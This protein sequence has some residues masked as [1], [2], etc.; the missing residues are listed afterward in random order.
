MATGMLPQG[1]SEAS[2][3]ST[4]LEN[5][6][7]KTVL[8]RWP[9]PCD[10]WCAVTTAGCH[11]RDTPAS[12]Q[13]MMP[14]AGGVRPTA[15]GTGEDQKEKN[16]IWTNIKCHSSQLDVSLT[17]VCWTYEGRAVQHA[18]DDAGDI[19]GTVELAHVRRHGHE[20]VRHRLLLVNHI[21]TDDRRSQERAKGC[22]MKGD[23]T[24]TRGSTDAAGRG[25]RLG[26]MAA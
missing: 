17:R 21:C 12:F 13:R 14:W 8:S 25:K 26:L 18:R 11:R 3:R 19:G 4:S 6:M 23:C 2:R 5:L 22:D 15:M 1:A 24:K 20:G 9:S 7:R 10:T 16:D